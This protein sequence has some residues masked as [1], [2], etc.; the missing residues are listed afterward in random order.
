MALPALIER[1]NRRAG[2]SPPDVPERDWLA[3]FLDVRRTVLLGPSDPA[4]VAIWPLSTGRIDVLSAL[5]AAHRDSLPAPFE[6]NPYGTAHVITPRVDRSDPAEA[7][8]LDR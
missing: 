2:G 5:L 8:D 7:G 1:A 3:A 4:H 6:V